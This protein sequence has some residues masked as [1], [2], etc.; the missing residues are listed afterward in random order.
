VDYDG[1]PTGT[2]AQH[3]NARSLNEVRTVVANF[4]PSRD[5]ADRLAA[6][7]NFTVRGSGT[8]L[9]LEWSPPAGVTPAGYDVEVGSI[10]GLDNL[11]TLRVDG[12]STALLV[13][14]VPPGDYFLRVRAR[15]ANG[16][17]APSTS[18]RVVM[19]PFGRCLAPVAAPVLDAPVVNGSRVALSWATPATG[20]AAHHYLI[21]AGRRPQSVDAA[22]IRTPAAAPTF[23]SG[24]ELGV[25][26]V[27]VA[28]V[29]ECGVGEASN[30]VVAVVGP[31]VPGPPSDLV[32][33][34]RP[35]ERLVTLSWQAPTAGGDA[36]GY[37][38]EAGTGPGLTNVA[39]LFTGSPDPSFRVAAPAGRYYVRVRAVN[40]HG[41]S[42]P[43]DEILVTVF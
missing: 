8:S 12:G 30:E 31:P 16:P 36:T 7:G 5:P 2:A 42:A 4:R 43:S 24:A 32:A 29:N 38:V 20:G 6:P 21:G 1:R 23:E 26:F 10:E 11:A 37:I 41:Q 25:Y 35:A 34:L 15:N 14:D 22:V 3:H 40:G 27:R 19:T 39:R 17:G 13:R 28:G 33:V 9:T 18:E